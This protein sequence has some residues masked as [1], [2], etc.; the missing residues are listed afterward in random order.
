M[1]NP[2]FHTV[3]ADLVGPFN[4]QQYKDARGRMSKFKLHDLF[5]ADLAT[6]LTS[7]VLMDGASKIDVIKAIGTFAAT[8]RLPQ[9]VVTDAGPQLKHLQDNPLFGALMDTGITI[10]SVARNHQFLNFSERSIQVWKK[11]LASMNQDNSK[12]VYDQP[13]TTLQLQANL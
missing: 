7:V 5:I 3:S 1:S 4:V 13:Q 9:C 10:V 12:S 11:L 2:L 8:K 6:S